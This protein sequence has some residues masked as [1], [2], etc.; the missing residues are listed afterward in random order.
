MSIVA[1]IFILGLII[2]IHE[3]GHFLLAKKNGITVTEF[4][5][6]MGP[7]LATF[8]KNGTRYSLKLF[9]IGGSCMMLGEDDTVDDE[10]AFNKK[11]VWARFSVIIA[12]ALF[13]FI[14]AFVL[15]LIVIGSHGVDY[16]DITEVT[17]D[18]AVSR[19]GLK[20][21]DRITEVNGN[22]IH[23][24]KEVRLYFM[25]NEV[26]EKPIEISYIRDG[27][28]YD[29]KLLP[30]AMLKYRLGFT[31]SNVDKAEIEEIDEGFP[32]AEQGVKVGDIITNVNGTEIKSGTDIGNYF[33]LNPLSDQPVTITY[34]HKGETK[35]VTATPK[36]DTETY[37]INL[38]MYGGYTKISAF[39]T[40]KYSVYELKYN[41]NSTIKSLMLLVSGKIKA[42]EIAGPV[43]IVNVV[44]QVVSESKEYGLGLKDVLLN[45]SALAILISANLG[46]MNLLP[47][48]ALDGGRLVF[49]IIEA[50]RGK[51]V[52]KEREAMV[53]FV[54]FVL[55]MF[56]MVF[57]LYNDIK[58]IFL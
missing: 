57:V 51:A 32:L 7:R 22:T 11:G 18:T 28:E 42:D 37:N 26:T 38:H 16:A 19:A 33:N 34:E 53:H 2:F 36:Y 25:L 39:E 29:V 56:L 40:V 4:S 5:L 20:V 9:P 23:F 41:I 35:V 14:L 47:L 12:G 15:A 46:V 55:L 8:V 54:G 58:N 27:K 1:A 52:P 43:G 13:N 6:G 31:Y 48:P 17:E 3:L 45:L 24:N 21:G 44:D 30:E 49:I 10:G 50:I